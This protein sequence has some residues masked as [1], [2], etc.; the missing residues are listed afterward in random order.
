MVHTH[1][2]IQ[3]THG[4]DGADDCYVTPDPAAKDVFVVHQTS[5]DGV[6]DEDKVML[7]F[8]DAQAARDAYAPTGTTGTTGSTTRHRCPWT[9][10]AAG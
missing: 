6:Y 4:A 5:S 8:S 9:S 10:S 7:G 3:D 1:R 2:Y